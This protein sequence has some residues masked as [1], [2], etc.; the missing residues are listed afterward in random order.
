VTRQ[1]VVLSRLGLR[2]V[3]EMPLIPV[4]EYNDELC[5]MYIQPDRPTSRFAELMAEMDVELKLKPMTKGVNQRLVE[6]KLQRVKAR[7]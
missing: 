6:R 5:V 3:P 2:R 1:N 4:P 7:T